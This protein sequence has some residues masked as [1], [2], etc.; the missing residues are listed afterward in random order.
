MTCGSEEEYLKQK[1]IRSANRNVQD[2]Q[3]PHAAVNSN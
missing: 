2:D 3:P 1:E